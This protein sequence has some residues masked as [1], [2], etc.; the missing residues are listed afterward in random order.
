[1]QDLKKFP[2]LQKLNNLAREPLYLSLILHLLF[3]AFLMCKIRFHSKVTIISVGVV[4]MSMINSGNQLKKQETNSSTSN[5]NNKV[6]PIEQQKK[7]VE[8]VSKKDTDNQVNKV[9]NKNFDQISKN[10][11]KKQK[12]DNEFDSVLK[13]LK[14]KEKVKDLKSET[15][16]K[17][18]TQN[19]TSSENGQISS[20]D[21]AE[22][23]SQIYPKWSI[24]AG[25]KNAE[26]YYVDI[27]VVLAPD[28]KVLKTNVVNKLDG[29]EGRIVAESAIRAVLLAS[30]LKFS[31]TR[32]VGIRSFILRFDL[33]E[34]LL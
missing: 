10:I 2:W 19:I 13:D 6:K 14:K 31:H 5:D 25:I 28:G 1:M 32:K 20:S 33:K 4:K 29:V 24:P 22:I 7:D 18:S 34:A 27:E 23:K 11:N 17:Q 26:D 3:F 9:I 21:E 8:K 15:G 30:P 12:I 16:S